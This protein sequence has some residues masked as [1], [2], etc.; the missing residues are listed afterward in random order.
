M[1][2]NLP[3]RWAWDFVPLSSAGLQLVNASVLSFV[4]WTRDE[5]PS[6]VE[7]YEHANGAEHEENWEPER[8]NSKALEPSSRVQAYTSH[9]WHGMVRL[10]LSGTFRVY[11]RT[12]LLRM[13]IGFGVEV[14]ENKFICMNWVVGERKHQQRTRKHM[15]GKRKRSGDGWH[16]HRGGA[17]YVTSF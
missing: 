7:L 12:I 14:I 9:S 13:G 16:R 8:Q 3:L 11:E 17:K 2:D 5:G 15:A 4:L 6:L 10:G 1:V